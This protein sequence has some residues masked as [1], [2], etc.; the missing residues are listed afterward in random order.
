MG[1]RPSAQPYQDFPSPANPD[2]IHAE[3]LRQALTDYL[4]VTHTLT[5]GSEKAV[6]ALVQEREGLR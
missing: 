2:L 3:G 4:Y 5:Y 1:A 6:K